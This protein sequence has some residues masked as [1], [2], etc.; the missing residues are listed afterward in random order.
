MAADL[1]HCFHPHR[2]Y[3]D[4]KDYHQSSLEFRQLPLPELHS[5]SDTSDKRYK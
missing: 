4:D 2:G 1:V 3:L 5:V